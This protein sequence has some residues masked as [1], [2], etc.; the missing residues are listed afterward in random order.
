MKNNDQ[1]KKNLKHL[2]ETYSEGIMTQTLDAARLTI[3]DLEDV[4]ESQKAEIS[5]LREALDWYADEKNH[6]SG[7]TRYDEDGERKGIETY[8]EEDYGERAKSTLKGA[9]L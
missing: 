1:P 7:Y 3:T 8:I 6:D 2:S 4:V 9:T 5:K